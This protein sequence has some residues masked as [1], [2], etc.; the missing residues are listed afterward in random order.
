MDG[1]QL[2]RAI[3]FLKES[4]NFNSASASEDIADV[5]EHDINIKVNHN[6]TTLFDGARSSEAERAPITIE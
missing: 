2:L 6:L 4:R 3:T 5:H 1:S